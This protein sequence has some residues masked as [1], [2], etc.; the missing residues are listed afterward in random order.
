MPTKNDPTAAGGSADADPEATGRVSFKVPPFWRSNPGLW[1]AQ[2]EAQFATARITTDMA[3]YNTVVAA[4]E[5]AVL[6]QVSDIILGPAEGQ[7]YD[8]LKDRL[9]SVFADSEQ[10]QMRNNCCPK[11]PSTTK[12]H[13]NCCAKCVSWRGMPSKMIW[14]R[15][16]GLSGCPQQQGQFCR[17]MMA[18]SHSWPLWPTKL[19]R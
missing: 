12:S 15:R 9:V 16:C 5:S 4:I 14:C 19:R 7:N 6:V 11:L 1:F 3:K 18:T 10:Q 13:R 2:I 17:Q 8:N